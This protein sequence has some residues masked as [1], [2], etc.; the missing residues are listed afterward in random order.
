MERQFLNVASDVARAFF[1][2]NPTNI[3]FSN[4]V[5]IHTPN[6]GIQIQKNGGIRLK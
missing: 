5:T 3:L 4:G 1:A 6:F 2:P